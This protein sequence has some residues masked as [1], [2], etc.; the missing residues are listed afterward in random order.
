MFEACDYREIV[1]K[2]FVY[3]IYPTFRQFDTYE[4]LVATY[5]TL[6]VHGMKVSNFV[7]CLG[8]TTF[9]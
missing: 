8:C 2:F 6:Y 7:N 4:Q 9:R 1:L 3:K 5:K